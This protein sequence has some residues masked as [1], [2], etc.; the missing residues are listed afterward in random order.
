M[1]GFLDY[2]LLYKLA[3]FLLGAVATWR[4]VV[5]LIRGRHGS[6]RDEYKFAKEFLQ[7]L[8][9]N[10]D[11][12]PFLKQKGFQAIAGDPRLSTLEIEYLLS[13]Q[14]SARALQDYVLGSAYLVHQV[15]AGAK[16]ITFKKKY[17][18]P[19]ARHWRKAGYLV[20]YAFFYLVGVAP[21]ILPAFKVLQI[22]S[23]LTTFVFS[24]VFF[25]PAAFLALR[26]GYRISRAEVLVST[27]YRTSESSLHA[28][29]RL[30][31]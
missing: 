8:K 16:Q 6:L 19:W 14:D 21:L 7:E 28:D 11:M 2:E 15:T 20:L 3:T 13:L 26:A 12:H 30:T 24:V 10:P 27:Q 4:V 23:A 29:R 9:A 1:S 22:S 18:R 31:L 17:M 5:E 25:F